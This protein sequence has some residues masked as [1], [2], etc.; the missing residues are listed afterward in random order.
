MVDWLTSELVVSEFDAVVS[1]FPR[2]E[3]VYSGLC[4]MRVTKL[5][6]YVKRSASDRLRNFLTHICIIV[7]EISE[8]G[9]KIRHFFAQLF[10]KTSVSLS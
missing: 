5:L 9:E 2:V 8:G 10:A 3:H 6:H 1:F 7:G 4:A